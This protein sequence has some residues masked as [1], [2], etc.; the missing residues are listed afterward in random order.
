MPNICGSPWWT[1]VQQMTV[2]RRHNNLHELRERLYLQ[3]IFVVL[4]YPVRQS[5]VH[6]LYKTIVELFL[7]GNVCDLGVG[8]GLACTPYVMFSMHT[9]IP[10]ILSLTIVYCLNSCGRAT[11]HNSI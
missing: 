4:G 1:L 8:W 9:C 6:T 10:C 7:H 2:F 3:K 11:V 5:A